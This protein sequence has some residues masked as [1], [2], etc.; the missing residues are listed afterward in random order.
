MFLFQNIKIWN[1][2]MELNFRLS[3]INAFIKALTHWILE[4]F[5]SDTF[6]Q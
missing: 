3:V 4:T 1:F 2:L 6:E 5:M